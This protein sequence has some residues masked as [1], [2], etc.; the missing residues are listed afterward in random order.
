[1]HS[2]P[3]I[4]QLLFAIACVPLLL[5]GCTSSG[6]GR[7]GSLFPQGH[8]LTDEA[9]DL[10]LANARALHIPRELQKVPQPLYT[11]EPGDVLLVQPTNLDSPARIPGDQPVLPD[12]T[13]NLGRY[14]LLQVMGRTVPEIEEMV[15]AAVAVQTKDAGFISV[16][17]VSRQS[18][19]Y[20]VIGEVNA[21]GSYE[22]IGRE[23]VLD[24]ILRAG[25]LTDAGSRDDII[26]SRPTPPDCPRIVLPVCWKQ[27]TQA[28]D[29]TTNYQLT[30][31]DR[32]FVPTRT[33]K[34]GMPCLKKHVKSLCA[35]SLQ[36]PQALPP[37]P[38]DHCLPPPDGFHGTPL[39]TAPLSIPHPP[40]AVP[41]FPTQPPVPAFPTLPPAPAVPTLP[42]AAGVP[43]AATSVSAS[44]PV[45][46]ATA[47]PEEN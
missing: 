14:G 19:V 17:I 7:G 30:A 29:T 43:G 44:T 3:S 18:K 1:M 31:G 2:L 28:G 39:V 20:Y 34:E 41:Q 38:G 16:R 4:R 24:G 12:G 5:G 9:R 11:V 21:P 37:H 6:P 13:I 23:T 40:S 10:R 32:I 15:Q 46:P 45:P 47:E 33:C 35:C 8:P 22:L 26:L 42:P 25:G 27:I 36:R